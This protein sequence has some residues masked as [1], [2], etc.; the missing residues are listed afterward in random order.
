MALDRLVFA[1]AIAG[2][3]LVGLAIGSLPRVTGGE[4]LVLTAQDPPHL[5]R[6]AR[7][8]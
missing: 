6:V 3:L 4:I 5:V 2:Y 8:S 7:L 1:L